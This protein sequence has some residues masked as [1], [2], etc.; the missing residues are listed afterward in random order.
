M[1]GAN[2]DKFNCIFEMGSLSS[3]DTNLRGK[4]KM[5]KYN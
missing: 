5:L 4:L 1:Y 2:G 3:N